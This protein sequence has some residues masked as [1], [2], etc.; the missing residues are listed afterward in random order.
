MNPS[1]R[2]LV[3]LTNDQLIAVVYA[4]GHHY[5]INGFT[6]GR[7]KTILA[8]ALAIRCG[9]NTLVVCPPHLRL[10]WLYEIKNKT[11]GFTVSTAGKLKEVEALCKSNKKGDICIIPYTCLKDAGPLFQWADLVI[12]DEA[13]YLKN[14]ESDRGEQFD[15]HLYEQMPDRFIGLTGTPIQNGTIEWF[16]LLKLCSYN[17]KGT[18]GIGMEEI[19]NKHQFGSKFCEVATKNFGG[20]RT[21]TYT[22]TTNLKKLEELELLKEGKYLATPPIKFNGDGLPSFTVKDVTLAELNNL[23]L[24]KEFEAGACVGKDSKAKAS[25]ALNIVKLGV[26][27]ILGLIEGNVGPIVIFSDHIESTMLYA[28]LLGIP[29]ITGAINQTLRERHIREFQE[30]KHR[31]IVGTIGAMGTGVTLTMAC[32][33][34]ISDPPWVPGSLAQAEARIHRI[35]QTRECVTHRLHSSLQSK[36]IYELLDKK[37]VDIQRATQ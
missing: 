36:H 32:N 31:G 33:V 12:A 1:K 17:P 7:G 26:D 23:E 2:L 22:G 21:K 34:V 37:N 9:G 28:K 25:A 5:S 29:Y 6:M 13:H 8:L 11:E 16:S 10:N 3:K 27:Y 30:G 15:R 20:R 18:S 4:M 19:T 14:Q 35:G 24:L